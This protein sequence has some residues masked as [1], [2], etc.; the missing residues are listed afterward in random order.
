MGTEKPTSKK[1]QNRMT[2]YEENAVLTTKKIRDNITM[3][4]FHYDV[5]HGFIKSKSITENDILSTVMIASR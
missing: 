5:R 3:S 2:F 4:C 1:T